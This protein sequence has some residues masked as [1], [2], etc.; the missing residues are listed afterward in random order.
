MGVQVLGAPHDLHADLSLVGRPSAVQKA[1]LQLRHVG[2][3]A[4]LCPL[5]LDHFR[6]LAEGHEPEVGRELDAQPPLPIGAQAVPLPVF[7]FSP[8]L[9]SMAL[10]FFGS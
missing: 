4:D 8:I 10:A 5:Q 2:L 1:P 6:D 9:S 7:L 3:D